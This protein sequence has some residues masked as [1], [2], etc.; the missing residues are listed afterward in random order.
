MPKKSVLDRLL[1]I[2]A[3]VRPGE[4]VSAVLLA[5]NV[6]YLLAFYSV[7][8]IVRDALI[9]SEAG[10]VAASYAAAGQAVLM[11]GF[12][13]AYGAFAS[14]VSRVWLIC[15]VTLFFASHLLIFALLG[16]AGVRIGI[17]FYLWIGV[18]NMAAV[19]QFWAFAND[20]YTT[21]RGKRLFPVVGVGASLGAVVGSGLTSVIFGGVGPYR[22]MLLAAAGL[23][24]PVGLTIW[25][26][27]REK[28]H[29]G[30]HLV[31]ADG[32]EAQAEQP[33]SR[34][35]GFQ[36]VASNRYL[37]LI[38][39]LVLTFTC[40][41]TLGGF[42]LNTM[43]TAEAGGDR[44]LIG[45]M[46]GQIQ[47]LV[48][49]FAFLLQAFVV[50]R[51]FK[52]AGVRAALFILPIIALGSYSMIALVPLFAVV[53]WAKILE[54]STDYSVQNT[55]RHALFLPTSREAKYKAK[56]AIDSFFVRAGDLLQAVVV[57]VGSVLA[58]GVRGYALVNLALV[59]VW[60]GLAVAIAREHR[61]L[62]PADVE[63]A[64]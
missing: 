64:A 1:S 54:N 8:K 26:H 12:V 32:S 33:L 55:T 22:L 49:L 29:A 37:R 18:F 44:A 24:V 59:A 15:G 53:R 51:I 9:L 23:L 57:F 45:Q 31:H 56:Q 13:P 48:N 14:R 7:L 58:F 20:L 19:A 3:D 43:I 36:L 62:A 50:S 46:A 11:L 10:A 27:R 21:E 38:A 30:P 6:F 25:V 47:T 35:G 28:A 61:A 41:N 63:K 5:A 34:A 16:S 60:L 42:I 2:F 17:A 4:G 39:I 52:Y 40:V